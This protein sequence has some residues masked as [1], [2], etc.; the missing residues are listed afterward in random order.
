MND[1]A[2]TLRRRFDDELAESMREF[3]SRQNDVSERLARIDEALSQLKLGFDAGRQSQLTIQEQQITITERLTALSARFVSHIED[4]S[5]ERQLLQEMA[6]TVSS[7]SARLTNLER[8]QIALWSV[9]FTLSA[10][11]VTWIIGHLSMTAGQ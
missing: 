4:E 10:A 11:G 6:M 9:L 5:A 3:R 8:M 7:H 2:E 1:A